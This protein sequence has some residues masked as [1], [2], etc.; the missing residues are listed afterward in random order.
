M[1]ERL[2][3]LDEEI[4]RHMEPNSLNCLSCPY[5]ANQRGTLRNHIESKHLVTGG[6]KCVDCHKVCPTRHALK[7][8]RFRQH[9]H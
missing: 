4:D 8:H 6:F 9:R 1:S 5:S 3:A 7:N 2:T